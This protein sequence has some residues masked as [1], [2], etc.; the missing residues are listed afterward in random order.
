MKDGRVWCWGSNS[1]GQ[2]GNNSPAESA[3]PVAV[4]FPASS[5]S[6]DTTRSTAQP[7]PAPASI[8]SSAHRTAYVLGGTAAAVLAIV[9]AAG[10]AM[11]RWRR[12]S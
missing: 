7:S 12:I 5:A 9:F 4:Q 11:R 1:N 8:A 2:L 10:W 3:L 6:D